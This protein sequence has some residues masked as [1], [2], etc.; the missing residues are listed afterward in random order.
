VKTA[1]GR[2]LYGGR[3]I[4]PDIKVSALTYNPARGR[5]AEAAFYFIRQIVAGNIKGFESYK[6]AKQNYNLTV[7]NGEF[8][9]TDKLYDAF[10][11]FTVKNKE[12]GLAAENIN[13]EKDFAKSR[14]RAELATANNSSEAGQQVLLETDPQVL[15]AIDALPEAKKYLERN[16]ANK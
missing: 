7:Q 6:T 5:V 16:L 10:V 4:E 3:G 13:A 11:E 14:L 9:I 15:K 8:L 12:N 1:F 2:I